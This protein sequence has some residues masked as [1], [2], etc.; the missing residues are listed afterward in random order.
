MASTPWPTPTQTRQGELQCIR[1]QPHEDEGEA[2]P[3]EAAICGLEGAAASSDTAESRPSGQ[4]QRRPTATGQ[5]TD[6]PAPG[7]W[8]GG[9]DLQKHPLGNPD[10]RRTPPP[11]SPH[12]P[13][14]STSTASSA[15]WAGEDAAGGGSPPARTAP[16]RAGQAFACRSNG[17][18]LVDALARRQIRRREQ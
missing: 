17:P 6:H 2:R 12:P 7:V 8:L 11:P 16:P 5:P 1:I 9:P 13:D 3:G 10:G 18:G 4:F 15:V 14:L